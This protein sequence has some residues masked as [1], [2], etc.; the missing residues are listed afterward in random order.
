MNLPL[1]QNPEL[2]AQPDIAAKIALWY[3]GQRVKPEIE[4]FADTTSV[5]RKI[6]PG[7]SGLEDRHQNFVSYIAQR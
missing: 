3:W 4:N 2:A 1:E 6:N 5:T 7:L